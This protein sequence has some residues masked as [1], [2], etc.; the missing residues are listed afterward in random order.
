MLYSKLLIQEIPTATA[1]R[2]VE[3]FIP[4]ATNVLT[5]SKKGIS[6]SRDLHKLIRFVIRYKKKPPSQ[7]NMHII[8][9]F[10]FCESPCV[11]CR[12][13]L[14][15]VA[16]SRRGLEATIISSICVS[17]ESLVITPPLIF[18]NMW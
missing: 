7:G 17:H 9:V 11:E 14:C 4:V 1:L 2:H 3:I 13:L 16:S 10:F 8:F 5:A 12:A 6:F 15:A 18:I